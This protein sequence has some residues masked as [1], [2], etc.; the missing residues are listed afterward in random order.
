MSNKL[1]EA[2]YRLSL[3]AQKI[4][5]YAVSLID[6]DNEDFEIIQFRLIDFARESGSDETRLYKDIDDITDE[7]MRAFF[8][9]QVNDNAWEKYNLMSSCKYDNGTLSI[10]F[11]TDMKPYLLNLKEKYSKHFLD[12]TIQFRSKYSIR[13]YQILKA[14]EYKVKYYRLESLDFDL[15]DLK[16]MLGL[17]KNQYKSFKDFRVNVLEIAQNEINEKS[18]IKF[19]YD[20]VTQGRKVI[21]IKFVIV[22]AIEEQRL[23]ELYTEEQLEEI[24]EKS[25]L[26][27][28]GLSIS[29][30]IELYEIA[31]AKTSGSNICPYNYIKIN[32]NMML[33]KGTARNKFAYLK[34]SLENDYASAATQLAIGYFL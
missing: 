4:Y 21:G 22:S 16:E 11:D 1:A 6:E 33:D 3:Q 26:I 32:Y 7:L 15:V 13:I 23:E 18:D 31:V 28:V 34:S 5:L 27:D 19:T 17:K 9:V 10:K 30:I 8:K 25:G 24:K 2:R 29:Q 20:T 12:T 14:N